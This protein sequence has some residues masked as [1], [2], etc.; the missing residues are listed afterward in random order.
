MY[1]TT[2]VTVKLKRMIFCIGNTWWH[3]LP[4]N[5]AGKKKR[6]HGKIRILD[7]I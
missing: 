1:F 6:I 2:E 3:F 4:F 5:V 7:G